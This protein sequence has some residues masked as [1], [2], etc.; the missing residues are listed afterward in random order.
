MVHTCN[1]I[2]K[3]RNYK[4]VKYIQVSVYVY[5]CASS[6]GEQAVQVCICLLLYAGVRTNRYVN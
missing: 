5:G 3:S 1:I 2:K 6:A 4:W